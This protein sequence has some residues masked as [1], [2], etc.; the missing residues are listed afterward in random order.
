MGKIVAMVSSS[1]GRDK[2]IEMGTPLYV[3]QLMHDPQTKHPMGYVFSM[4]ASLQ[5]KFCLNNKKKK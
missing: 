2:E 4:L 3:E 1:E 5:Q